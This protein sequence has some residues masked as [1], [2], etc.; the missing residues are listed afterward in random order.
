MTFELFFLALTAAAI[1]ATSFVLFTSLARGQP[2]EGETLLNAGEF[3]AVLALSDSTGLDARQL[4]SRALAAKHLL[5]FDEAR[6]RGGS[7]PR[8]STAAAELA[9]DAEGLFTMLREWRGSL[10]APMVAHAVNNAVA[11]GLRV[12][13]FGG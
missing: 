5:R 2:D 8:A 1:A 11:M 7:R 4:R 12:L 13:F 3:E 10:V 9:G 6:E